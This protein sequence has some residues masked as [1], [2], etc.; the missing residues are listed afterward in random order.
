MQLMR[1]SDVVVLGI[2]GSPEDVTVYSLARYVP[3][4]IFSVV[5]IVISAVM[6]GLGGLMG[7]GDTEPRRRRPLAVDGGD[8]ADRH[9]R[10]APRSCSCTSRSS[11]SGSAPGTPRARCPR[12]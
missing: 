5:A 2:A 4:A 12:C 7:A 3:E 1:A 6:P 11:T 10:R 8:V 9:R